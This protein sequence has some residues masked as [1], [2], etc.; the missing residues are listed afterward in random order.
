MSGKHSFF[1]VCASK[2][3]FIDMQR[4]L[5]NYFSKHVKYLKNKI[6]IYMIVPLNIINYITY[7]IVNNGLFFFLH[8]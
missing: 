3:P 5:L 2:F 7:V 6:H 4:R 8:S 1:F